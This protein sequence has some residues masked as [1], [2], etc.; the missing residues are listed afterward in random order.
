MINKLICP[1]CGG[2]LIEAERLP[3][4]LFCLVCGLAV[5]KEDAEA[6]SEVDDG[7]AT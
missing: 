7:E 2:G 1:K 4:F 5:T 3:R 6:H